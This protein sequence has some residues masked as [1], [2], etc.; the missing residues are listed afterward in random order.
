[1]DETIYEI[2]EIAFQNLSPK[3]CF[4]Y[5]AT[6]FGPRSHL[7][8]T[9][10]NENAIGKYIKSVG[11][12]VI[13]ILVDTFLEKEEPWT[14]CILSHFYTLDVLLQNIQKENYSSLFQDSKQ[15]NSLM[16]GLEKGGFTRF[17]ANKLVS[18]YEFNMCCIKELLSK[19]N[20]ETS[21]DEPF[22]ENSDARSSRFLHNAAFQTGNPTEKHILVDSLLAFY[23]SQDPRTP[24]CGGTQQ[25]ANTHE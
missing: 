23:G 6:I 9:S 22:S 13:Y 25:G 1:M 11:K 20:P 19:D 3:I 4:P 14:W 12:N 5:L 15:V 16:A 18:I 7:D 2:L 17:P 24:K 8:I 10:G 21:G